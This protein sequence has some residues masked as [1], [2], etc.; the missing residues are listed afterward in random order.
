MIDLLLVALVLAAALAVVLWPL[1]ARHAAKV[2][3]VQSAEREELESAK[4]AKYREI[5]DVE[6][7]YRTGKLS[8]EDW[9]ALDRSLRAEALS[10]LRRI[11]ALDGHEDDLSAQAPS[12]DAVAR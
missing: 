10:I 6:M 9:R 7:D 4:E 8:K 12:P 11:D 3:A 1:T 2:E 5:R